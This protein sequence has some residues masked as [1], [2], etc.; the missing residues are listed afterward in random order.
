LP[1][2]KIDKALASIAKLNIDASPFG[3]VDAVFADGTVCVEGAGSGIADTCWSRDI[4]IQCNA[5]GAMAFMYHGKQA[6]GERAAKGML[7]TV[8]RGPHAMPWAQPCGLSSTT[9]GTCHGHDYYDHMVVWSY[10]LAFAG[11]SIAEAC[12]PGGFVEKVITSAAAGR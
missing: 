5:T 10:P 6:D 9:G 1:K 11:Q 12:A 4:F 2:D 8:F 7:D 3:M